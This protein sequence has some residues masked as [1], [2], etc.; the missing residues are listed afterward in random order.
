[1]DKMLYLTSA[2]SIDF[3]CFIIC[4]FFF[5]AS[6]SCKR[7]DSS[8]SLIKALRCNFHKPK[9]KSVPNNRNTLYN[10]VV[11]HFADHKSVKIRTYQITYIQ[12]LQTK[13]S[14]QTYLQVF[15]I[16]EATNFQTKINIKIPTNSQFLLLFL[17][18]LRRSLKHEEI[19]N[20]LRKIFKKIQEK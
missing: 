4:N 20:L 16:P 8:I 6:A 13:I 14:V 7:N 2:T 12:F 9:K 10:K 5:V 18:F 11:K 15:S 17:I 1:M 19:I 3:F